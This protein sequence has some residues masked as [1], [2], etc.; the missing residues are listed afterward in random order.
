VAALSVLEGEGKAGLAGET[1]D[2]SEF[3]G[4]AAIGGLSHGAGEILSQSAVLS[5]IS[6]NL[7]NPNISHATRREM[8]EFGRRLQEKLGAKGALVGAFLG[9]AG[10]DGGEGN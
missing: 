5:Y 4:N 8:L 7:G 2:L 10:Q 1:T 6:D 3:L 9:Q